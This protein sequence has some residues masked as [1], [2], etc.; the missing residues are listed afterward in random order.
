M[1]MMGNETLKVIGIGDNVV[2]N[3]IDIRTMF[4]GGNALNFSVYAS[5]LGCD[6]AYLGV[7]GS[8]DSARHV[9]QTLTNIGVDTSHCRITDGPNGQAILQI[10]DGERV[11]ISSNEGGISKSVPMEFIFD[12]LDYLQ[13]FSI[14]H[15]SAYSYM[16]SYLGKIKP[17][18]PLISYDFSDDFESEYALSLC[19]HIDFGFFSCSELAEQATMELLEEALNRGCT[20]AVATRGPQEVI[21]FDGRSWFRQAPLKVTPTDT[22]GAGDAFISGFLISYLKGKAN[23]GVK[24]DSLIE[25]A[26]QEAVAFAAEICQVQGAFGHGLPY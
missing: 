18:N 25:N 17:L 12:D 11:F 15:T 26:L 13:S 20:M 2:D 5:M 8:D 10:Q 14:V 4:P 21:L 24:A 23:A 19:E 16:D 6:A 1:Q 3:Y 22:L 7:F 9:Q